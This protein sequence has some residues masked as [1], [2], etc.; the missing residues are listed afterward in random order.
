[1]VGGGDISHEHCVS[2]WQVA[3]GSTSR[4]HGAFR[5]IRLCPMRSK[6]ALMLGE[7]DKEYPNCSGC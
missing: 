4:A 1:M 6:I 7:T 3:G 5:S 2:E